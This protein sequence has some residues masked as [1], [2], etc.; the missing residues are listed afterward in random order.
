[1][2]SLSLLGVLFVSSQFGGKAP[3][4]QV[5]LTCLVGGLLNAEALRSDDAT[6]V[7][8]CREDLGRLLGVTAEPGFT[9]V[10]R[11]EEAVP[12]PE[13]GYRKLLTGV[14]EALVQQPPL[15]LAGAAYDGVSVEGALA[16]GERAAARLLARLRDT[17]H[18]AR[19]E[20]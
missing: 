12:Q 11:W 15:E 14:K 17:S 10:A 9:R 6:L 2:G 18:L 13:L 7:A 1:D 5:L 4:G 8:R 3:Q 16:G 19:L 20:G